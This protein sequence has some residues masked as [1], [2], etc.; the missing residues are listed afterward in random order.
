ME[1]RL[2]MG[3]HKLKIDVGENKITLEDIYRN[4]KFWKG[5]RSYAIELDAG[6][7]VEVNGVNLRV[8]EDKTED[9][10][11]DYCIF[12]IAGDYDRLPVKVAGVLCHMS[13]CTKGFRRDGKSVHYEE[14]EK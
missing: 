1:G 10:V 11:C 14:G 6:S 2:I 12:K 5:F 8:V 13:L 3:D 4:T 9:E 7:N